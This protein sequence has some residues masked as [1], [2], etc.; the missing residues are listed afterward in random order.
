[1]WKVH[2]PVSCISVIIIITV[3]KVTLFNGIHM[4]LPFAIPFCPNHVDTRKDG[5]RET[6]TGTPKANP[7]TIETNIEV[8]NTREAFFKFSR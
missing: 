6:T 4:R 7:T 3:F 5:S 8:R 2:I 1:M